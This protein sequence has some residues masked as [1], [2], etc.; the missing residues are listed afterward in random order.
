[1][2]NIV[3]YKDFYHILHSHI[4][5]WGG[6]VLSLDTT[7]LL[8]CMLALCQNISTVQL[9]HLPPV[10]PVS[11][12]LVV[13]L[14]LLGVFC[15]AYTTHLGGTWYGFPSS[16]TLSHKA[17]LKSPIPLNT[18]LNSFCIFIA[19]LALGTMSVFMLRTCNKVACLKIN[20]DAS[21]EIQIIIGFILLHALICHFL[22]MS[23]VV[24]AGHGDTTKRLHLHLMPLI[25]IV[26]CQMSI[27]GM[28]E[29]F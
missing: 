18:S 24:W 6:A 25:N 13:F 14:T 11:A 26:I 19:V 5:A 23:S 17:P 2:Q 3:K 15:S 20:F 21:T 29:L 4:S 9:F 12:A 27:C 16:L 8:H 22:Y 1:M 7:I 28:K 10:V